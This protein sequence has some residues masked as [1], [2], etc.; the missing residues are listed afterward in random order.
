MAVAWSA[1]CRQG[2]SPWRL[3][4]CQL[5]SLVESTATCDKVP[6]VCDQ[7][8]QTQISSPRRATEV[9]WMPSKGGSVVMRVHGTPFAGLYVQTSRSMTVGRPRSQ[10]PKSSQTVPSGVASAEWPQR[11]S[12]GTSAE[13]SSQ[14]SS[15]GSKLHTSFV[16]LKQSNSAPP[17]SPA[18]P[19]ISNIFPDCSNVTAILPV[20]A[21]HGGAED[22]L[23]QPM[24]PTASHAETPSRPMVA[25][26]HKRNVA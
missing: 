18:W 12:H 4:T 24:P 13:R 23:S 25:M 17:C 2:A 10:Q 1:R 3:L 9:A 22:A 20:C 11:G 14:L 6:R 8:P 26:Q 19:A 21:L 16:Q 15:C 7:P 5:R